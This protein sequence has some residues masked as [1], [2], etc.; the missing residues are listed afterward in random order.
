MSATR[1]TTQDS[2]R[3]VGSHEPAQ[4]L[5]EMWPPTS[6]LMRHTSGI[7]S[8]APA[9]LGDQTVVRQLVQVGRGGVENGRRPAQPVIGRRR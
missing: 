5:D 9:D 8:S 3:R 1:V 4:E 6:T 7:Q 2:G